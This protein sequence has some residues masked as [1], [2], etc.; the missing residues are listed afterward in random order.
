MDP[1]VKCALLC[2]LAA[3]SVPGIDLANKMC[4]CES[5][6]TC[7]ANHCVSNGGS[8]GPAS[9][10]CLGTDPGTLLYGDTFD[11]GSL[12]TGWQTTP[13]WAQ[14]GG[15]LVQSDTND[16]L[17]FAYTT[18]VTTS[19]YR[20]VAQL[21]GTAAGTGLGITMRVAPGMKTQYDC[22]WEAGTTGALVLQATNPGGV[23]STLKSQVGI[24]SGGAT[25]TVTMEVL[26][27]GTDLRCCLDSVAGASVEVMNPSPPYATGQPGLVTDRMVGSFDNFE[28]Y[29]N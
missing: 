20:V 25:A 15:K 5:G 28:V 8:D 23:P 29:A 18:H 19:D 12:D 2:T 21:T 14:S 1:A 22:L 6:Y 7:V 10:S 13:M 27:S 11:G 24:P 3:C 4:P 26:A 9:A 17:A 16:Q